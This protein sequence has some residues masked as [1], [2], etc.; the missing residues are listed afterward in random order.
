MARFDKDTA[1]LSFVI[2]AYNESAAI[3]STIKRLQAVLPTLELPYEIIVVDDG[4]RDD[5]RAQ[6]LACDVKVVG[7]PVNTGYGSALKSGIA[8]SRYDWIG[9]VDA[10]G[11]YDIERL[12]ELVDRMRDGFDMV[13]A[14]RRNVLETDPPF[15]RFCRKSMISLLNLV[16]AAKIADPN[17]G[18]R[19]FSKEIVKTFFPFLCNTFS[20]TTSLTVF[21]LGEGYFVSYVPMEYGA[22]VGKSKVRHFRDSLRM[23]QL[24]IQGIT[25]FNPVKFFI[26]MALMLVAVG[27][28]PALVLT[29]CGWDQVAEYYFLTVLAMFLLVGMGV[30]G[31]ISRISTI[32]KVGGRHASLSG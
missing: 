28:V 8:V 26:I 5:T 25:Y 32:T 24:I 16:I 6:A 3:V 29:A 7:H 30:L 23:I 14:S 13:V 12:P 31:D 20:F 11:T 17:S 21:A 9:I 15:K 19:V 4:S 27:L 18:F 2:P 10:D 1:G 22:R